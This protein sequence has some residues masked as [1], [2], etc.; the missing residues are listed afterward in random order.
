LKVCGSISREAGG[1]CL[2]S[3]NRRH[4]VVELKMMKPMPE[5][6]AEATRLDRRLSNSVN[7]AHGLTPEKVDLLWATAPPRMPTFRE[8]A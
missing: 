3:A 5:G 4:K 1:Q 2:R 6:R 8:G 7:H